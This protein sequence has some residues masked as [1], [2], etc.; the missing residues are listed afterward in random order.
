MVS[1]KIFPGLTR[2]GW[3]WLESHPNEYNLENWPSILTLRRGN[4]S[5]RTIVESDEQA[6]FGYSFKFEKTDGHFISIILE[7]SLFWK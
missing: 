3:G 2:S 5:S 6:N 7:V 1:P 4:E